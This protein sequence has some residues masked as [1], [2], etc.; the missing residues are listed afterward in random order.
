MHSNGFG[1]WRCVQLG[2]RF[3]S[4]RWE[5]Q[6]SVSCNLT[7]DMNNNAID[8]ELHIPLIRAD[9]TPWSCLVWGSLR[10]RGTQWSA[11]ALS[12]RSPRRLT[13]CAT[14]YFQRLIP[15]SPTNSYVTLILTQ[16]RA[17]QQIHKSFAVL[18]RHLG[19]PHHG[20]FD[21]ACKNARWVA[22]RHRYVNRT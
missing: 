20:C 22:A 14:S 9:S 17:I 5:A 2:A 10:A 19:D 8:P 18:Q 13:H 21:F 6:H 11:N 12:R 1:Y 4:W 7:L 15:S 16:F 3:F